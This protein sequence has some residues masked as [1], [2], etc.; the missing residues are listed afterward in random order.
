MNEQI[1]TL[2]KAAG[3]DMINKAA[4]RALGFDVE[5]FAELIVRECL[6]CSTWVGKVNKYAIEPEHTAH[7]INQ[8]IKEHFGVEE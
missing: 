7:T 8:R 4:M 6:A 3:Y 2:A 5:K 1:E